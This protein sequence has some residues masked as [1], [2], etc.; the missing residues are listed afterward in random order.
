MTRQ[1]AAWLVDAIVQVVREGIHNNQYEDA[2]WV[3]QKCLE[4]MLVE[5]FGDD[6]E[7]V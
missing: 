2:Q 1:E 5:L 6:D 4:N 3:E 7:Q